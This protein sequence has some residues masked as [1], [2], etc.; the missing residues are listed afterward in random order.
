VGDVVEV[1]GEARHAAILAD[2]FRPAQSDARM[3]TV[4]AAVVDQLWRYPAKSFVGE[5]RDEVALVPNG[6]LGD[7]GW[8]VRD[9]V[10][11]GIRG[12]KKIPELMGLAARYVEEPTPFRPSPPIEIT[13]PDGGLVRSDDADVDERLSAAID[14]PVTLWPLQSPDNLDHYRRGRPDH[15]DVEQELRAV[16]GR[17]PHEPLPDLTIFPPELVEFESPPGTYLDAFPLL[18]LTDR[19]L[20]TLQRLAPE[21]CMDV[22]RF[23][24]NIFL[25]VGEASDPYPELRWVGQRMR[26]GEAVVEVL[27]PCPRCVMVTRGFADLPP[28]RAVLRT[29]V[30]D[31]GQ[32][33]GVYARVA[34]PG[35]VRVGDQAELL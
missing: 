13:L 29:I 17:E 26:L 20:A 25:A 3:T 15:A 12:A 8:A 16:F 7:R 24:P 11:G 33:L 10:R 6:V 31:A 18:L 21:S 28:D 35:I 9:E 23:R 5:R 4:T 1:D 30:R 34:E 19:S 22:R 27:D 32:D 14:H 2:G